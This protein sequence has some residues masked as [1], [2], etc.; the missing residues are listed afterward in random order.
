MWPC[1]FYIVLVQII[2]D[3]QQ[4]PSP[5]I[6]SPKRIQMALINH[7]Y[8]AYPQ[9]VRRP[10]S[11]F[12][13]KVGDGWKW[14]FR[15]SEIMHFFYEIVFWQLETFSIRRASARNNWKRSLV[16]R[17]EQLI[18]FWKLF[19]TLTSHNVSILANFVDFGHFPA[20]FGIFRKMYS[21]STIET[22]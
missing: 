1:R 9:P 10:M 20:Y 19:C 7:W 14:P 11:Y 12:S 22:F 17:P 21:L 2:C 13:R 18:R 8:G 6:K 16:T 3:V 15:I 5:K 4:R